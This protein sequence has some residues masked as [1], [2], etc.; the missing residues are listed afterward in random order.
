VNPDMS[1]KLAVIRKSD[2]AMRTFVLLG[3]LLPRVQNLHLVL[4]VHHPQVLLGV[5]V[6]EGL[7][8]H[9]VGVRGQE[10]PR[11]H[12]TK[13]GFVLGR[14]GGDG[15]VL[16][17]VPGAEDFGALGGGVAAARRAHFGHLRTLET[18]LLTKQGFKCTRVY[19]VKGAGLGK[20]G[21]VEDLQQ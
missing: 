6:G 11:V 1:F 15:V 19:K 13:A 7:E 18:Q 17:G 3:A 2:V 4:L 14:G 8:Q 16:V 12:G 9:R 20:W 5:V 21:Y 10:G